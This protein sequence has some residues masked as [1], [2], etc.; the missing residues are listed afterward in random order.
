MIS[1]VTITY[2]HY[3]LDEITALFLEILQQK[4]SKLLTE[5]IVVHNTQKESII[6]KEKLRHINV[7]HVGT[8]TDEEISVHPSEGLHA[9]L[10]HVTQPYI[11]FSDPDVAIFKNKFDLF[12]KEIYDKYDLNIIGVSHYL[13]Q[14]QA[15]KQFPTVINCMIKK[16]KLP[17]KEWMAGEIKWRPLRYKHAIKNLKDD[18]KCFDGKYLWP[19]P[20]ISRYHEFPYTKGIYDIGCNLFLWDKDNGSK[21]LTFMA[22]PNDK[23]I[24]H[25]NIFK[26]NFNFKESFENEILLKHGCRHVNK[27]PVVD[28][29]K[30]WANESIGS[31]SRLNLIETK[32]AMFI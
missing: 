25:T 16:N 2:G 4:A 14:D 21:A 30:E 27:M 3:P 22:D 8:N 28:H 26:S 7:K 6:G 9:G 15:F 1:L 10:E 19:G 17:P 24:Y 12:Y 18:Y 13:H 11:I 32:K 23:R 20:I 29:M 5:V 31:W